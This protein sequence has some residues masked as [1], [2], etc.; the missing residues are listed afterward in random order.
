LNN[1]FT[2][3]VLGNKSNNSNYWTQ[4]IWKALGQMK[5]IDLTE[6]VQ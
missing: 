3:I 1:G 5:N 4:P 6:E 2:I